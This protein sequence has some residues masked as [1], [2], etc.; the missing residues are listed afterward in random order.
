M[1]FERIKKGNAG[2]K[3]SLRLRVGGSVQGSTETINE[4][5]TMLATD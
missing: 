2:E 5:T 3:R 1:L 4:L